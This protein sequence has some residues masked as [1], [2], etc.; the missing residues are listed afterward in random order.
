MPQRLNTFLIFFFFFRK[1]HFYIFLQCWPSV[2]WNI[3]IRA[4]HC[5][6]IM[7]VNK[8]EYILFRN[9]GTMEM[10]CVSDCHCCETPSPASLPFPLSHPSQARHCS[11]Y[12]H[13]VSL[14][15]KWPSPSPSGQVPPERRPFLPAGIL[16][17]NLSL[18]DFWELCQISPPWI[19]F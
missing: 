13:T 12:L 19:A 4:F 7:L 6:N 18:R 10:T 5:A 15:S 8:F 14:K 9:C 2:L 1:C 3:Y 17:V 11:I 16:T